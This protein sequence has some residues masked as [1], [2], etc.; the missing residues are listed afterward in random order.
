MIFNRFPL[1]TTKQ[2]SF[3]RWSEIYHFMMKGDHLTKEGFNK[4]QELAKEVNNNPL[5][6]PGSLSKDED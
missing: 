5:N 4:I 6:I 3:E 1:K 2:N